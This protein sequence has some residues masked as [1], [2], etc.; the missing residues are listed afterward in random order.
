MQRSPRPCPR[1]EGMERAIDLVWVEVD[2]IA[3]GVMAM[4]AMM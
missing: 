4:V 3:L 2:C 1:G